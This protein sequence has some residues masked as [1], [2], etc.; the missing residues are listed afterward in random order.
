MCRSC[1]KIRVKRKCTCAA[2]L[3]AT[4]TTDAAPGT[5]V[6][7]TSEAVPTP[8]AP[9]TAAS[10]DADYAGEFGC[11]LGVK[12][13]TDNDEVT[14]VF[15]MYMKGPS[16]EITHTQTLVSHKKHFLDYLK[17]QRLQ[18]RAGRTIA[19]QLANQILASAYMS[20]EL[21]EKARE[22]FST[23]NA[24]I[25]R[26]L[27]SGEP[28][29]FMQEADDLRKAQQRKRQK[30][31]HQERKRKRGSELPASL[32]TTQG[33]ASFRKRVIINLAS[34][35]DGVLQRLD[36]GVTSLEDRVY[37]SVLIPALMVT[38]AK[39]FRPCALGALTLEHA[40]SLMAGT[41]LAI[42]EE[43]RSCSHKFI[44]VPT[45]VY[46]QRC[47]KLYVRRFRPFLSAD[48]GCMFQQRQGAT[49][50]TGDV[51]HAATVLRDTPKEEMTTDAK[52]SQSK[53]QW[54]LAKRPPTDGW[55][56]PQLSADSLRVEI[57]K[58]SYNNQL[59]LDERGNAHGN[60]GRAIK[61]AFTKYG[62]EE[63]TITG[64]RKV[65]ETLAAR[66]GGGGE[67]AGGGGGQSLV[68]WGCDHSTPVAKK[69][70]VVQDKAEV[71]R[72]GA[73]FTN[74]FEL[75]CLPLNLFLAKEAVSP[76]AVAK[77]PSAVPT[78]TAPV[79]VAEEEEEDEED[80]EDD[81]AATVLDL[82]LA[83]GGSKV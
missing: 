76:L 6:V 70:Y 27:G 43:K 44:Y 47:L 80:E 42:E 72:I 52:R 8:S 54:V 26:W 81:V 59:L 49:P 1:R 3:H 50:T 35:L 15:V 77:L 24:L 75:K 83:A 74:M 13:W 9:T 29:R 36:K 22:T 82:Q 57:N 33:C 79:D 58:S 56:S 63:L 30:R 10:Q 20:S 32:L 67:A 60:L 18:K 45:N 48:G 53:F 16:Q 66:N 38:S 68:T 78:T 41:P 51:E 2:W 65:L 39:P 71:L 21:A 37:M 31:Q 5:H 23:L 28:A 4:T 34:K 25:C 61:I 7:T 69:H 73:R 12:D 40:A 62:D 19:R 11:E 64:F 55:S 46:I 17:W 14:N